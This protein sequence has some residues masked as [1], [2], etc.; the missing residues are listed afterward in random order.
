[1]SELIDAAKAVIDLYD[2]TGPLDECEAINR[3]IAAVERAEKPP[4]GFRDW[5]ES[6]ERGWYGI[7]IGAAAWAAA[8]QAERERIRA[9]VMMLGKD[10]ILDTT[11][12]QY[13]NAL[14]EDGDE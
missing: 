9:R 7:E 12:Q 4:A 8:Q 6:D 1:M 13:A 10:W 2:Y 5:W 14:L 3:L 11:V